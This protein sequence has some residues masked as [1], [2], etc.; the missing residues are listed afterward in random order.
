[1][2]EYREFGPRFTAYASS[3]DR[4]RLLSLIRSDSR[5]LTFLQ[6]LRF[7]AQ[8]MFQPL[9]PALVLDLFYATM[10]LTMIRRI[11]LSSGSSRPI[12]GL[13]VTENSSSPLYQPMM[14][15]LESSNKTFDLFCYDVYCKKFPAL[16]EQQDLVNLEPYCTVLIATKRLVSEAHTL[17]EELKQ[18]VDRVEFN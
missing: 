4:G 7:T 15:V 10:I 17:S 11:L 9:N 18:F 3:C 13:R 8:R 2:L 6:E 14:R 16:E 12:P 1:M 5:Y